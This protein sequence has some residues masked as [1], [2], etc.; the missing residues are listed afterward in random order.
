MVLI[1]IHVVLSRSFAI[2]LK[3][4]PRMGIKMNHTDLGVA[5]QRSNHCKIGYFALYASFTLLHWI[6]LGKSHLS[7]DPIEIIFV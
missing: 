4:P 1:V 2:Y 3:N 6:L 5:K 7:H